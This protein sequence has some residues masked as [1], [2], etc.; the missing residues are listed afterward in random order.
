VNAIRSTLKILRCPSAPGEDLHVDPYPDQFPSPIRPAI[1]NYAFMNGKLGPSQGVG[2]SV[3]TL[4]TGPFLY[5][6]ERRIR[7]VTDGLSHT[8]F[9]GEVLDPHTRISS[10]IWT[11]GSRHGDC[12]RT[13]ENSLNTLP[14]EGSIITSGATAGQ[15]GAFGSRHSQ[16]ALFAFGD[17]HVKFVTDTIDHSTYN[18][19]GTI[20]GA[21]KNDGTF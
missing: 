5:A 13:T 9:V 6:I 1:G 15:N 18:S 19:L 7:Q 10:N 2:C 12:L 8:A 21:E 16:G 3:K 4:N 17:G 20:A 11:M 14:G